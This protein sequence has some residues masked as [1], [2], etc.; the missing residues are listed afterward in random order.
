MSKRKQHLID[1]KVQGRLI[2]RVMFHWLI[3]FA[4]LM[5]TI[6]FFNILLESP[7]KSLSDRFSDAFRQNFLLGLTMISLLPAFMLDTIRFSNR[8][9]GPV[10]RLR[11]AMRELA[12]TGTAAP[13]KFRDNDFWAD[14]ATEFNQIVEKM[15]RVETTSCESLDNKNSNQVEVNA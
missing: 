14:A 15:Q 8:F 3:F 12:A 6:A 9:V 10:Y 11:K 7:E 1:A 13:L 4:V 2:R 5:L